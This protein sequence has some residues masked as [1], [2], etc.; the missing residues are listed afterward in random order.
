MDAAPPRGLAAVNALVNAGVETIVVELGSKCGGPY[1]NDFVIRYLPEGIRA[2]EVV[3]KLLKVLEN[4]R[5]KVYYG[6]TV[7]DVS[8]FTGNFHVVL[9]N[10]VELDVGAIIV[11]TGG[12]SPV[13]TVNYKVGNGLN[14][15]TIHDLINGGGLNVGNDVLFIDLCN[16]P[17]CQP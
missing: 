9:S 6:T 14:V 11:A 13:N 1:L 16:K 5:V 7:K 15:M 12:A 4:P 10:G 17:Y 2:K 3:N 8:G